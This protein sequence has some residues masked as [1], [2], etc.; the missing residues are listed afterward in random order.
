MQML[1]TDI[2]YYENAEDLQKR[3][4]QVH[5]PGMIGNIYATWRHEDGREERFT[6]DGIHRSLTL[7]DAKIKAETISNVARAFDNLIKNA[8]ES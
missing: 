2:A 6:K 1:I 4:A 3:M 7:K 8:P 5:A